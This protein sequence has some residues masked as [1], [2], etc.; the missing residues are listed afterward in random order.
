MVL[1]K[2]NSTG[3]QREYKV[4][5]DW[6]KQGEDGDH[7]WWTDGNFSCDCNRW[8]CFERAG[9]GKPDLDD[10]KCGDGGFTVSFAI[11]PNGERIKID[12]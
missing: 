3:K 5:W 4:D 6:Y 9:G 7:Y 11:L 8:L 12:E 1:I 10:A 2:N